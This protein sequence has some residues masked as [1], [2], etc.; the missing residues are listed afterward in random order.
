MNRR[1]GAVAGTIV[2]LVL[3]ACT[4]ASTPVPTA[5]PTA[6]AAPSAAASAAATTSASAAPSG[7]AGA[8][9]ISATAFDGTFKAMAQVKSLVSQ[10]K[11][12]VGVIL[13]D[14]TTSARYTSYDLPYLKQAFEAA[15][16]APSDY[17]IDNA[18]GT[19]TTQLAIAQADISAGAKVLI[20][21]P[22]DSVTG[23]QVQSAA[24]AA[25][26]PMISYDRATFQGTNT[27]YVSFDNVQVGKLIG[28]GF[29]KCL[30]DWGV[31]NPMVFT[32]DGG[33]DT[34]PNA[35]DFAKG[36]N[37][38]VWGQE[39]AQVKAGTT[40]DG[41]T[42]VG[43]QIAPGWNNAQGGS[44]FQQAYTANKSINATIEANDG[45]AG[46]VINALKAAGVPAKKIPTTG[47]D[48]TLQGMQ[49]VLQG[50]QCGS[51]YKPIY[52]EAQ[53]AVALATYMRAGQ[54]PPAALINGKTTDPTN[55]SQTQPAILL[56]PAW[57]SVDNMQAT[58]IT[59]K[60]IAVAD[61]CGAVG[62]AVCAA[63]G[64]K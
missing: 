36:Y 43:E 11:G 50:W 51:V 12:L 59:D 49:Y 13:P 60:A 26:V 37:G 30:R 32:L 52:L 29:Q 17:K 44:I 61:L 1:S 28:T 33:Q 56:T 42:L 57:V 58:V 10:G 35:I 7:S 16:Y 24:Q 27:Y 2:S 34:D 53:A 19:T 31:T 8:S 3:A 25:G 40:K 14:T 39:V 64:I 4:A 62:Q 15:G 5:A 38:V 41:M 47:Q 18:A 54:Q 46:A 45:L 55:P 21:D 20:V 22:I 6:S 63:A 23:K 48:A 9:G